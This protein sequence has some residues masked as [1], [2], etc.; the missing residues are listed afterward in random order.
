MYYITLLRGEIYV[1]KITDHISM[2]E[3]GGDAGGYVHP[4]VAQKRLE[5]QAR[6]EKRLRKRRKSDHEQSPLLVDDALSL[7]D[8]DALI[9]DDDDHLISDDEVD[10]EDDDED[11]GGPPPPPPGAKISALAESVK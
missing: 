3:G 5:I 11:A 1:G 4:Y 9:L 6:M 8:D 10:D 2:D 7:D